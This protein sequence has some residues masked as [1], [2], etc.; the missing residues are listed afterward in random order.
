MIEYKNFKIYTTITNSIHF[1]QDKNFVI[2]YLP[3]SGNLLSDYSKLNLRKID[4]KYVVI[5]YTT[6]PKTFLVSSDLNKYKKLGLIPYSS[7]QKIPSNRNVILDFSKYVNVLNSDK[8]K[9]SGTQR[10][11]NLVSNA[12]NFFAIFPDSYQK[13]LLFSVDRLNLKKNFIQRLGFSLSSIIKNSEELPFDDLLLGIFSAQKTSYRMLMKDNSFQFQKLYT[14]IRNIQPQIIES[15]EDPENL[16]K[17]TDKISNHLI[18][19]KII[20]KDDELKIKTTIKN[21]FRIKQNDIQKVLDKKLPDSDIEKIALTSI[22][23]T[24]SGD[25]KKAK[26]ISNS[27]PEKKEKNVLKK[28]SSSLLDE[29]VPKDKTIS[30]SKVLSNK[31]SNIPKIIEDKEPSRLFKKRQIDF[32]VNLVKDSANSFKVLEKKDPPLFLSEIKISEPKRKNNELEKS[33]ITYLKAILTDKSKNKHKVTIEIP[34]INEDGTFRLNGQRKCLINQIVPCPISFPKPY[35]SKFASSYSAFHITSK[36]LRKSS[37]LEI[38]I[39]SYRLPLILLLFY[40]FGFDNTLKQYDIEYEIQDTKPKNNIYFFKTKNKKYVI[41]NKVNSTLK[42]ELITSILKIKFEKFDSE[43]IFGTEEYF[44]DLIIFLTGRINSSYKIKENL[45][46]I[47]EPVA[48]QVLMNQNLPTELPNIIQYMSQ[49]TVEGFEQAKNDIS[50]MRIRN[51][52]ILVHLAQKQI[53]AAYTVY[54]E[55]ILSGNKNAKF[56]I[57]Q[58]KVKSDFVNSEIVVNMEFGNPLEEETIMTKI[59][60]VGSKIGGVP[61]KDSIQIDARNVHDS[62]FGNVDPLDTPEGANIGV[63]QQLSVNA[64]LTSARGIFKEKKKVNSEKSGILSTSSSMVPF[65][66]N[67]EGARIIMSDNQSRQVL[68]LKNPEPPMVQTGYESILTASLSDNF[69]KK[70]PCNGK[71]K[72]IRKDEIIISCGSNGINK[73][74]DTSMRTLKSGS[75]KDTLS[76]FKPVVEVGQKV[77]SG[78]LIAEGSCIHNGNICMGKNLLCAIMPYEG[79][80]FEDGVVINERIINEGKL[81]SL[82]SLEIDV[83]ISSKDKVLNIENIGKKTKRGDILLKKSIGELDELLGFEE[84]DITS[85]SSSKLLKKSPGGEIVDI[86]VFS[87]IEDGESLFPILKDL[88]QKTDSK[89]KLHSDK[90]YTKRGIP[91]DGILVKFKI[92]QEL[93]TGI[94]DKTCNRYG[95]KGIISLIEKDE[96]MPRTPWGETIDFIINPLGILNRMNIGQ[97]YELYCGLISKEIG[98]RIIKED[99]SKIEKMFREVLPT[100]DGS[101]NKIWSKSFLIN[102]NKMSNAEY[103]KFVD[104]TKEF[105]MFPIIAAAFQAPRRQNII[106]SLNKLNLKSKYQLYLPKYGIKTYGEVPVGYQYIQKLE[107]LGDAKLHARS[108][109]PVIGKTFQPSAGKA[110]SGGQRMGEQE[111]YSFLSYGAVLTLQE[112]LGPL[113]DDTI[114]KDEMI[115]QIVEE[116]KCDYH[117]PKATPTKNLLKTYFISLMLSQ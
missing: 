70:S 113:S 67:N 49:K 93:Q 89:Y 56:T 92:Q 80:N 47:V 110:N 12:L 32:Q 60:P 37:F 33:D 45:I 30:S 51:S 115:S 40:G 46:N 52:E 10:K 31:I 2:G 71:V 68:P 6:F 9:S 112:M 99:R 38:Y 81:T 39:A 64:M 97:L 18:S 83:N 72:S 48:K 26:Q 96:L 103:S 55:Q 4:F 104:Q 16:D 8:F 29:I 88:I 34:K 17:A 57:D 53:L 15:D 14:F 100:L 90:R 58:T 5:P 76:I 59:S 7:K 3:E 44:N 117:F 94:G 50:N 85:I 78:E 11:I 95:N 25:I 75:G 1:S 87:N 98:K 63:V 91:I 114:S 65:I 69:I 84:D 23:S 61:G 36:K 116:G 108:T 62:Y 28:V 73:K 111:S 41:F 109:G 77:N 42:K 35:S 106:E 54:R 66:E 27:I 19:K 107:H 21:Y 82:H 105:K 20:K 43:Y 86:E 24:T 22:L 13:I 102:L 74:I 79:F 101:D